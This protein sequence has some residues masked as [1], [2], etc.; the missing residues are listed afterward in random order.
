MSEKKKKAVSRS[1]NGRTRLNVNV[2]IIIG[3][4]ILIYLI[5]RFCTYFLSDTTSLYEVVAGSTE[6]RFNT[7][8]TA[9]VLRDETVVNAVKTGYVN[10]FIGDATPV[11]VGSQ[12]YVIDESGDL[13]ARLEEASRNQ[14][15]LNENELHQ[16]K[17]TI[18]DFDTSYDPDSY[19]DTYYFKYRL[20]SQVLDLINSNVFGNLNSGINSSSKGTYT[21][22]VSDIA[23]IMQHNVDGFEGLTADDVEA[24]LFRRA[25]YSKN[26]IKS[27]DL[28]EEGSPVYKVVTSEKWQLVIQLGSDDAVDDL[29]YVTIEF[30]SDG[31]MVDAPFKTFTKAGA[32][33]GIISLDKYMIRYISDRYVSI[34]IVSDT[35]SGLKI[36]KS[37]VGEEQFYVIPVEFVTQGGNST[38]SGFIKQIVN[39]DGTTSAEFTDCKI[40]KLTDE[41]AYVSVNDFESGDILIEPDTNVQYKI[42]AKEN[43]QGAYISAGGNYS[44]TIVD[45]LGK[46]NGFYIVSEHTSGGLRI[47][48][49]IL[50]DA[51]EHDKR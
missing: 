18:Y 2:W 6:G 19:Y 43:L 39:K 14:T 46:E 47:Y 35:F 49:Q 4:I 1:K 51:S 41:Y 10:F 36:P 29:D 37:S 3:V 16:I 12:T 7:Q 42:T 50:K 30:L 45:I 15:I 21:I 5:V 8:Y 20:E 27:N 25:N 22:V 34:Q 33:Y 28:I 23:G 32:K 31:I 48:D 13:S 40:A 17:D 24:A 44:F 9:L 26:I 11:N 38:G